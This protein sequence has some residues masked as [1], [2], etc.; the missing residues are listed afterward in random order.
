M[1]RQKQH[2]PLLPPPRHL[3]NH[4][5]MALLDP[6]HPFF[7]KPWRRWATALLPIGWAVVEVV[8]G[9]PGW[10]ILFF[11]LGAYAF[12]VLVLTYPKD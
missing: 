2:F 3:P 1:A 10:A 9:N 8:S 4:S 5:V 11:A 6:K 7:A 12:R